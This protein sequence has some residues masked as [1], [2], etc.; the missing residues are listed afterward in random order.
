MT[1]YTFAVEDGAANY[2]EILPLYRQHYAEMAERMAAIGVPVA[3]FAM[4][5]DVYMAYWKA[6]HLVNYVARCDGVPVGYG[7]FYLTHSMHNGA[8]I[9]KEDAIY[10]LPGHRNGTGRKLAKLVLDDLRSRGVTRLDVE[11]RTDPRATKLWQRM[12]F[13]PTAIAMSYLF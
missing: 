2:D 10:V 11:A 4:R 8:F 13:K 7:N 9:A 12:G 5:L 3:P 6:G 1:A